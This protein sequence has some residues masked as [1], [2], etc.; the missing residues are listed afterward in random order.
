VEA[1]ENLNAKVLAEAITR[2]QPVNTR[3]ARAWRQ[4]DKVCSAVFQALPTPDTALSSA[5]FTEG[6]AATLCLP[7]PACRDK[8]GEVIREGSPLKSMVT[9]SRQHL[10]LKITGT[11]ATM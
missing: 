2:V 7:S 6:A 5:E 9:M 1:L 10:Y 11:P 8:V 4:R 3:A